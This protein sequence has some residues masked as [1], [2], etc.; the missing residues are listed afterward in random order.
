MQCTKD[1]LNK[2]KVRAKG[3]G[4]HVEGAPP[5]IVGEAA[6]YLEKL[7]ADIDKEKN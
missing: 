2:F 7:F 5:C 4:F 3:E 6:D 1:T